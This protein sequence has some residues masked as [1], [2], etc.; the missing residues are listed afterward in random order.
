MAAAAPPAAAP[1][2][3]APA[4]AGAGL[5]MYT[6]S[7]YPGGIP[8]SMRLP[9]GVDGYPGQFDGPN[10]YSSRGRGIDPIAAFF[11]V[12]IGEDPKNF[13]F[14]DYGN[15]RDNESRFNNVPL[16]LVTNKFT[17]SVI[18]GQGMPLLTEVP[19]VLVSERQNIRFTQTDFRIVPA[20][21]MSVQGL[22]RFSSKDV[23]QYTMSGARRGAAAQQLMETL[24]SSEGQY[25]ADM[26]TLMVSS[27]LQFDQ[28]LLNLKALIAGGRLRYWRQTHGD[29]M[30]RL[31]NADR[32]MLDEVRY[33]G[34]FNRGFIKTQE[35]IARI[36][37]QVRSDRSKLMFL[38]YNIR[39]VL[40]RLTINDSKPELGQIN[41][42][43]TEGI[44]E[45]LYA[46]E[47]NRQQ[48]LEAAPLSSEATAYTIENNKN[49][50]IYAAPP[51]SLD[52][53][54]HEALGLLDSLV[55]I[56]NYWRPGLLGEGSVLNKR[57]GFMSVFN[58]ERNVRSVISP[59]AA[60]P[61]LGLW[62]YKSDNAE[63]FSPTASNFYHD[64]LHAYI[65]A[66]NSQNKPCLS[67][68]TYG[69]TVRAAAQLPL[70]HYGPRE[71]ALDTHM[72]PFVSYAT[73]RSG[74]SSQYFI[75][76]D[77]SETHPFVVPH[78]LTLLAARTLE[79]RITTAVDNKSELSVADAFN[80][81]NRCVERIMR[82]EYSDAWANE[83]REANLKFTTASDGAYE[84]QKNA[85]GG[86]NIPVIP[87]IDLASAPGAGAVAGVRAA[88]TELPKYLG[89]S[90]DS[91]LHC[92]WTAPCL[93]T[94]A[95]CSGGQV[96]KWPEWSQQI[97]NDLQKAL[98]V[99]DRAFSMLNTL[100]A[101]SGYL[102]P[103]LYAPWYDRATLDP[104]VSYISY[105]Y[106]DTPVFVGYP[107]GAVPNLVSRIAAAA[108]ASA[109]AGRTRGVAPGDVAVEP[110]SDAPADAPTTGPTYQ[111]IKDI[112]GLLTI[113]D[114]ALTS[115][116]FTTV[117]GAQELV[118]KVPAD[119]SRDYTAAR[120]A[121]AAANAMIDL[122]SGPGVI[123]AVARLVAFL[124]ARGFADRAA[125]RDLFDTTFTPAELALPGLADG[126]GVNA[127]TYNTVAGVI[128]KKITTGVDYLKPKAV[129]KAFQEHRIIALLAEAPVKVPASVGAA[130]SW[131]R[132][133]MGYV[134]INRPSVDTD[135]FQPG[136]PDIGYTAN[137]G[138]DVAAR[139]AVD[140]AA[141]AAR[142]AQ[143]L[144]L[145]L[146]FNSP[147]LGTAALLR[148][149]EAKLTPRPVGAGLPGAPA[150]F[151]APVAG[152][153]DTPFTT[154]EAHFG[155]RGHAPADPYADAR[156]GGATL[157]Q[158]QGGSIYR[159]EARLFRHLLYKSTSASESSFFEAC[160]LAWLYLPT[161]PQTYETLL[162]ESIPVIYD[163]GYMRTSQIFL[164]SDA[165]ACAPGA[166]T[167][168]MDKVAG[169]ISY[170]NMHKT[171]YL[172][173]NKRTL[174]YVDD[175]ER[176]FH[177][178]S[179]YVRELIGGR[180]VGFV[181]PNQQYEMQSYF[182]RDNPENI[183]P[184]VER[185]CQPWVGVMHIDN[186]V[187][188]QYIKDATEGRGRLRFSTFT[189]SDFVMNHA[190]AGYFRNA[191][192][193]YDQ[194]SSRT[195]KIVDKEDMNMMY[196]EALAAKQVPCALN[197]WLYRGFCYEANNETGELNRKMPGDEYSPLGDEFWNQEGL[198][199]IMSSFGY[200]TANETLIMGH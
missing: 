198:N 158:T 174:E 15:F 25:E 11:G 166:L 149:L 135:L 137:L 157:L 126:A 200:K 98:P 133:P 50:R 118:R 161:I 32:Q 66:L 154:R 23:L 21:P 140:A 88:K 152:T 110:S 117:P 80:T 159:R 40:P 153:P 74:T 22:A 169:F 71:A 55:V 67:H 58:D 75:P 145:F 100:C 179:V 171:V 176:V 177:A 127:D 136:N 141:Y 30:Y 33:F 151:V 12:P 4:P 89:V 164:T 101:R 104:L 196:N 185:V 20:E 103:K 111:S 68:P 183:I 13:A 119:A 194:K 17:F 16:D 173:A 128:L 197:P 31:A 121:G 44:A 129:L 36:F 125:V 131:Y 5:G 84:L 56:A 199:S 94:I 165:V 35:T 186:M 144:D 42:E 9:T 63:V 62:D 86:I 95:A 107:A 168:I 48:Y 59:I 150:G 92:F 8:T 39:D 114:V 77:H 189:S 120:T 1:A 46:T 47:I 27:S 37:A 61:H 112:V 18:I 190:F 53:K 87:E 148:K 69:K 91:W 172:Q 181:V 167:V 76:H 175:P 2:A 29:R 106:G 49:L 102:H 109:I 85:Y 138:R 73:D 178:P 143:H 156:S 124:T 116:A 192:L 38:P 6:P 142:Y 180:N 97:Y 162:R 54:D 96:D 90:A 93:R 79:N 45:A 187:N 122:A 24:R 81:V 52:G 72:F 34:A 193:T 105:K 19:R 57:P 170:N 83:V 160:W 163:T 155:L 139:G 26:M 147:A 113:G 65:D 182:R 64:N 60:L 14:K 51:A 132:S 28:Q 99:I 41:I 82:T 43:N 7:T 115:T 10:R 188:D 70:Q 130:L 191:R 78:Q 3:A 134:H 184:M 146:P 108:E 123:V 195:G